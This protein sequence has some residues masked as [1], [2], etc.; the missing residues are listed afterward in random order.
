MNCIKCD[1]ELEN[2]DNFC[3]KCGELTPHGYL[4][5][6]NK[7][8]EIK[9]RESNLGSIF[10]LVA[11]LIVVFTIMTL[12]SGKDLFRPYIEIKKQIYSLKYGYK[13]S[14][15]NT[16]NQY[17]GVVVNTNKEALELIK[18]DI[19][20]ESWQCKRNI[21]ISIIEKE[22]SENY[23]IPSVSLCDVDEETSTKIKN[24]IDKVYSM[25]PSIKGY[26]TNITITNA[27]V[28]EDYIACFEPIYTFVNTNNSIDNYNKVNK[29]QI[30]LNSYYFLN[31]DILNKGTNNIT[32][33]N[34]Y[35][36]GASYESLIAHELGHYITFVSLLKT[37][38]ISDITLVT[39]DNYNEYQRVLNILNE[40]IY[41]KQLVEQSMQNYNKKYNTNLNI[42]EFSSNISGYA[43]HKSS[44]G[45]IIYDEV[46]AEAIH[47][48]YLHEENSNKSTLE[49][50]KVIKERL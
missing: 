33:E 6:K 35:P 31:K 20:K 45:N 34:W 36:I 32:K 25:F 15:I 17:T 1:E 10:T 49:I 40:E 28:G 16:D 5:L 19:T 44:N 47:D 27:K 26:L 11:L 9:Y 8:N 22:I 50:I 4:S 43:G 3:P 48:Y 18:K 14:L 37:N 7:P 12:I 13:I 46:I 38:N 2:D 39:K 30:L 41:S 23:N 24:V 21:N 42:F 29:T